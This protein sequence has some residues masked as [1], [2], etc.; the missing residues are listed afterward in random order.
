MVTGPGQT[1]FFRKLYVLNQRPGGLAKEKRV[2]LCKPCVFVVGLQQVATRIAGRVGQSPMEIS[3][4]NSIALHGL[5][6]NLSNIF[7]GERL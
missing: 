3:P 6:Y 5:S 1:S 7:F 2:N 4:C